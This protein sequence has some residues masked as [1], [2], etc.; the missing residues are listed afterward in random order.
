MDSRSRRVVRLPVPTVTTW[1]VNDFLTCI[2]GTRTFWHDL[3][4]EFGL[5]DK[6]GTRF[7]Q[8]AP[9][10][11][12]A[13][14]AGGT[15]DLIIRNASYFRPIHRTVRTICFAQDMSARRDV[16]LASDLVVFNSAYTK[17]RFPGVEGVVIPI[18]VDFDCFHPQGDAGSPGRIMFVGA[19]NNHPKGFDRMHALIDATDYEY[20]LVLK[21]GNFPES[22]R[23][24]VVKRAPQ[25][26]MARLYADA[27][28][29]VCT[30][31]EE[32]L[33][34]A[35]VEAGACGVPVVA[36]SVGIYWDLLDGPWG[37][38][39]EEEDFA[40]PV[41]RAMRTRELLHPFTPRE[42]WKAKGL[43]KQACMDAWRKIL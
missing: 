36:P 26:E 4:D 27:A 39:C 17:S 16:M 3:M 6:T 21:D 38:K 8:L 12:G 15:P 7:D 41:R 34:L 1:L 25:A 31:R 2:P 11:E 40:P 22:K 19:V 24:K 43:T 23:V 30:S 13:I 33:H 10:I 32:T 29:L 5:V 28:L 35:G 9:A 18:G 37:L 20:L 42:F 14:D